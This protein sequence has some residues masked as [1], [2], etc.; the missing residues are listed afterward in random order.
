[1]AMRSSRTG[2]AKAIQDLRKEAVGAAVGAA[3][4]SDKER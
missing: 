1:M 4:D 2:Q 3:V